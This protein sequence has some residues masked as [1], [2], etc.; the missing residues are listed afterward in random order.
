MRFDF[1]LLC[2]YLNVACVLL[3]VYVWFSTI[4]YE[5]QAKDWPITNQPAEALI[6]LIGS[7]DGIKRL[8]AQKGTSLGKEVTVSPDTN[9]V[10]P[11]QFLTTFSIT[12]WNLYIMI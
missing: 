9:V 2:V 11:S 3:N 4:W 10:F 1:Y 8:L 5:L 12:H 6:W 7:G